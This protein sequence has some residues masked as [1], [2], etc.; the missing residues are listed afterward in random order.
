M[1]DKTYGQG[2]NKDKVVAVLDILEN[3]FMEQVI[4]NE[5]S[6]AIKYIITEVP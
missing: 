6:S 3:M 4:L 2:L 5:K 1:F